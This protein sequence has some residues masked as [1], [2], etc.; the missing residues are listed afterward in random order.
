MPDDMLKVGDYVE[1]VKRFGAAQVENI[2]ILTNTSGLFEGPDVNEVCWE[3][4][5]LGFVVVDL[6]YLNAAKTKKWSRGVDITKATCEVCGDDENEMITRW[7][8]DT[9]YVHADNPTCHDCVKKEG[10]TW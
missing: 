4:C 1:S 6:E 7:E 5:R 3:L 9:G 2:K 10:G 8:D